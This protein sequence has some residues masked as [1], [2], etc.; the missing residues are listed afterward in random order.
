MLSVPDPTTIKQ[1][2]PQSTKTAQIV[3]LSSGPQ[4]VPASERFPFFLDPLIHTH[5]FLLSSYA[6]THLLG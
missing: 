3:G 1:P 4:E 5:P 2:L 6:P